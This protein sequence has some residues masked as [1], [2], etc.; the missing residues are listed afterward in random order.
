MYAGSSHDNVILSDVNIEFESNA[1]HC[2]TGASGSGK[3]TLLNLIG[4]LDT[5]F[6]GEINIL[7]SNIHMIQ[8]GWPNKSYPCPFDQ[9][10]DQIR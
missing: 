4:C 6:L 10:I 3:T 2:I 8:N 7:D 5:D 1:I 9:Q